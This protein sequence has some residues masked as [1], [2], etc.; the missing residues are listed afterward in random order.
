MRHI[1]R[2]KVEAIALVQKAQARE[3]FWLITPA[4]PDAGTLIDDRYQFS[5]AC[6]CGIADTILFKCMFEGNSD[7]S[8][9][10]SDHPL[11]RSIVIFK[12]N[13]LLI[14]SLH[15]F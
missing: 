2:F 7:C 14:S 15:P 13:M 4:V 5:V 10:C 3:G 12:L 6:E 9:M 8:C 11:W 1:Q